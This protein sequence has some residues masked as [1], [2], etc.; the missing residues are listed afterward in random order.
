MSEE[1]LST[2]VQ[3]AVK[4]KDEQEFA[5]LNAS[6]LMFSED[7]ARILK[8]G[9]EKHPEIKDFELK[10]SHQESLHPHNAVAYA[11]KS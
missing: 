6:H 8:F 10:V 11:R 3:A 5:R 2:A 4:R 1:R 7:A 9:L